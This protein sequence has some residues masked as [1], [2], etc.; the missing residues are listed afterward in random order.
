[1]NPNT[2]T[3]VEFNSTSNISDW[4]VIND[5]I[6]G[7]KSDSG[8]YLNKEG[9]A[10]FK[11]N[12]SLENKGGFSMLKHRLLPINVAKYDTIALKLKG[13]GKRYQVR[14]KSNSEEQHAYASYFVTSGNW[15]IIEIPLAELHPTFRGQKL[16]IANY[17]NKIL[18]EI[19]IL[20]GNKKAESFHLELKWIALK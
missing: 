5:T 17:P 10:V 6:M 16:Q 7:G 2:A 19:A 3:L 13:D 8:F 1:M 9:D 4:F 12:I 11:G 18:E 20:I 15:Q 14:L